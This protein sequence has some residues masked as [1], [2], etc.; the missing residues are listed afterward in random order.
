MP[1]ATAGKKVAIAA[2]SKTIK[3][4][5]GKE[6][7]EKDKNAPKKPMS[8][9][10]C[11]QKAK[12][13]EVKKANPSLQNKELVQKMSE[14]WRALDAK[15]KEPYD[16][17]AVIE[18]EKYAK[19]KKIYDEKKKEEEAKKVFVLGDPRDGLDLNGMHRKEQRRHKCRSREDA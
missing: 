4:K 7:K 12:R 19:E 2:K 6:K 16:K 1:K 15:G 10:F 11:F 9:F 17:L 3:S 14:E 8:A 18:K 5:K 13:E